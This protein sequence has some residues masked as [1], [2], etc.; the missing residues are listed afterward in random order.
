LNDPSIQR[1]APLHI[2]Q[3]SHSYTNTTTSNRPTLIHTH[4]RITLCRGSVAR[5]PLESSREGWEESNSL[6]VSR[7]GYQTRG[8]VVVVAEHHQ[9]CGSSATTV[10]FAS[11]PA[12]ARQRPRGRRQHR[13]SA[14]TTP[15]GSSIEKLERRAAASDSAGDGRTNYQ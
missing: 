14:I 6:W 8:I 3:P 11:T 15:A 9:G 10:P 5:P 12:V 2:A 1:E 7:R 4:I 13:H